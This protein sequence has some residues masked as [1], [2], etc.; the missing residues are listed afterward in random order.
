[1]VLKQT[2]SGCVISLDKDHGTPTFCLLFAFYIPPTTIF[3]SILLAPARRPADLQS[4][5]KKIRPIKIGGFAIPP[6]PIGK[7]ILLA[8]D[9]KSADLQ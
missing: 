1:M 8:A 9:F 4:A 5:V 6:T 2:E 7:A 3:F